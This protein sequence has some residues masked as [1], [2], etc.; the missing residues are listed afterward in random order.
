MV[1]KGTLLTRPRGWG[2]I[3]VHPRGEPFRTEPFEQEDGSVVEL[4]PRIWSRAMPR[5]CKA[6]RA[7]RSL[8]D[9]R[10]VILSLTGKY[11]LAL[12]NQHLEHL[13]VRTLDRYW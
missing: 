10:N 1:L 3:L 11:A 7:Q 9:A 5:R 13:G 2:H 12:V 4:I 8:L 6:N